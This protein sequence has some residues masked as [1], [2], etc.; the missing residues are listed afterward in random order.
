MLRIIARD[1]DAG[2]AANVGGSVLTTFKT[3]EVALPEIEE[4]LRKRQGCYS[5]AQILGIEIIDSPKKEDR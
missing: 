5:H 3:F 1:D 2:M 4:W